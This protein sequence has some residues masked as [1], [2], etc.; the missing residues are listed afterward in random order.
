MELHQ[1]TLWSKR[2]FF[3]LPNKIKVY[4]KDVDGEAEHYFSYATLKGEAK[5]ICRKNSQ[6]LLIAVAMVAFS[7]C[8]LQQSLLINR[9]IYFTAIPFIIAI[10]LIIL[11]QYKQQNYIV[12]ETWV[13][14]KIVFLRNRPDQKT[15]ET[16]LVQLWR[17]RKHYLREKY[18]YINYNC[19]LNGQ[20]QRLRWLLEQNVITKAEYKFAQEDWIIDQSYRAY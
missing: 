4:L 6:L 8:L 2:S 11:Y 15:L 16:F 7:I 9:G 12:V 18:F 5:I 17:Y 3:L 1:K 13:G 20:T 14:E 19:D 10:S